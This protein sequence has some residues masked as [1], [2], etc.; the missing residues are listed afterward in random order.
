MDDEA[1]LATW[2]AWASASGYRKRTVDE[3]LI[4]IRATLRRT[5]KTI[6]TMTRYDLIGDLARDGISPATK[7]R[8]KSLFHG[9]WSWVQDEGFRLDCPAVRLPTVR[10]LKTE[11]NPVTTEDLELL[12]N[13]GIYAK[14]RMYVL[15]YAYQGFRASEIAAV[16][17]EAI[18]WDRK[19]LLSVDGKGGKEVWRPM[20]PLVWAEAQKYPR[21]GWWFRSPDHGGHVT[22]RNVSNVLGKAMKRAGITGHRPH[23]L[24]GWYATE[25]SIAGAPTAVVAAGLRHSDLQSVSRYLAVPHREID[26]AQQ[27]LPQVTIPERTARKVAA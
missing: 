14:T 2:A 23:H 15:L 1:I 11:P 9:F 16:S 7:Q 3:H 8:Y 12:I 27:R 22:G 26:E 21:T 18:D 10:V 17:G 13:S 25:L 5:G 20:H 6:L 4:S 24:R 19:R